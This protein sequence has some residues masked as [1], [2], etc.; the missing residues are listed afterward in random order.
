[1]LIATARNVRCVRWRLATE[2]PTN[3]VDWLAV[4]SA[5]VEV[6]RNRWRAMQPTVSATQP[7]IAGFV[8]AA[9]T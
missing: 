7:T 3:V 9:A 6:C 4:A 8:I 1:M 5:D 2:L